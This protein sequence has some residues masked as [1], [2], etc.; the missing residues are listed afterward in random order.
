MF[1]SAITYN[2][3]IYSIGGSS[4]GGYVNNVYFAQLTDYLPPSSSN[5]PA[6]AI[7]GKSVTVDVLAGVS[8]NPDP[9]TLQ[10]ITG[11]VHG[12]ATVSGD[13]ITYT[14]TEGYVGSDSLVF[15]VCSLNDASVC[16]ESI[17]SLTVTAATPNT[18]LEPVNY[19]PAVITL[20]AGIG[21]ILVARRRYS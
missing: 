19:A 18:G 10:I 1:A 9:S 3:H 14:A 6:S 21:L 16:T 2:G 4:T 13:N 12:T 5:Q 15:R 8:G 20:V 11:P 7:S 17:L